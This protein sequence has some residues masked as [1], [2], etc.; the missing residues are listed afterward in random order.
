M[1]SDF[2]LIRLEKTKIKNLYFLLGFFENMCYTN[3]NF[4]FGGEK[5]GVLF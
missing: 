1:R 2:L 3:P 5:N 4:I